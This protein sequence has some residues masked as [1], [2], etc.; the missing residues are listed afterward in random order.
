[1]VEFYG[2]LANFLHSLPSP[3][4]AHFINIREADLV[5]FHGL[6]VPARCSRSEPSLDFDTFTP[7]VNV[8]L[9]QTQA[10]TR[11]LLAST[12]LGQPSKSGKT[13]Q[14]GGAEFPQ[15][16]VPSET[17][18]KLNLSLKNRVKQ[19]SLRS[20]VKR[21]PQIRARPEHISSPYPQCCFFT[22]A[23]YNVCFIRYFTP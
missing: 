22:I 10:R 6:P 18:S 17:P 16:N 14:G 7:V 5:G 2:H 4:Q 1:M 20:P 3:Y 11:I 19:S 13:L 8:C 21:A 23:M 12:R 15:P 9:D